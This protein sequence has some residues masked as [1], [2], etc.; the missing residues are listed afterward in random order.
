MGEMLNDPAVGFVLPMPF[1]LIVGR[2]LPA[3]IQIGGVI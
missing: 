1:D 2:E 3:R